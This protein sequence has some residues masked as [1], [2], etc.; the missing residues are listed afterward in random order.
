ML[1]FVV[2][3]KDCF[4]L[5]LLLLL[6]GLPGCKRDVADQHAEEEIYMA[7]YESPLD[8][9]GYMDTMGQ[10]IIDPLYDDVGFFSE[11]FANVNKDGKWGFIDHSGNYV[12]EPIYKAA[13]AFQE[14]K[15]RV[16][17]FSGPDH[18]ITPSGKIIKS[19]KWSA[20]DDFSQGLAKVKVGN[21]FGYI[22]TTG[23]LVL[24][25][26]YSR[27]WGFKHGL[28]IVSIDEKLGVI[29]AKGSEILPQQFTTLKIIE[30]AS[31]ILA[32][33]S[34]ETHIYDLQ[35]QKKISLPDAKAIDSDGSIVT[36]QKGGLM[37]FLD[38]ADG[39][40]LKGQGWPSLIYLGDERWAGKNEM[41]FFF[42][43]NTGTKINLKPFAQINKCVDGICTYY[44]GEH[45]GYMDV[46]G[47]ELTPNVFGL[48]WDFKNGFARA[49]FNEGI[50]F[51]NRKLDLAFYPPPGTLDM[52]DFTE[53][54]APVQIA[55]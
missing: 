52:K 33:S 43:D 28:A 7:D 16:S 4:W 9:W 44:T 38:L 46:K 42:L 48:A 20:A 21:T 47:K 22:D 41:G 3:E 45:W 30:A 53:G 39:S 34:T 35:G 49:A 15:A 37:F 23:H 50:A 27:A 55:H 18:Y 26:I 5:L 11:G 54:L 17:P 19:E 12:I 24:P 32:N 29:N 40:I 1:H 25:A 2:K 6:T 31:L 8:K 51:L 36:I 10:L 14:G 13:W